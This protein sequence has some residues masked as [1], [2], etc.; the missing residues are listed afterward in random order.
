MNIKH[1]FEFLSSLSEDELEK[2]VK[3]FCPRRNFDSI[4]DLKKVYLVTDSS[5]E[6]VLLFSS[7]DL[8][9][10]HFNDVDF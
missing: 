7:E 3:I 6:D 4:I 10:E 8:I 1:V 2:S 5:S 9:N